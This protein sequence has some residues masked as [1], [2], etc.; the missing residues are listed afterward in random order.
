MPSSALCRTLDGKDGFG[1][2]TDLLPEIRHFN[3][4][5]KSGQLNCRWKRNFSAQAHGACGPGERVFSSDLPRTGRPSGILNRIQS[6]RRFQNQV[7]HR[8]GI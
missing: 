1:M 3:S 4:R 6:S 5:R 7:R 2:P 8:I